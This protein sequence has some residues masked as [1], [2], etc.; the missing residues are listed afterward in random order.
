[1]IPTTP[2]FRKLFFKFTEDRNTYYTLSMLN[3]WAKI[4]ID[5]KVKQSVVVSI[6]PDNFYDGITKI[7]SAL[8]IPTP[9]ITQSQIDHFLEFNLLKL[10]QRD[11]IESIPFDILEFNAIIEK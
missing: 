6:D 7:A 10:K 2:L 1:M 4:V 8:K 9:V 11:F 5:H 3:V